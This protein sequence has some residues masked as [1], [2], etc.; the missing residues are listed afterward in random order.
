[1]FIET[2]NSEELY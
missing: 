1:M 2:Q